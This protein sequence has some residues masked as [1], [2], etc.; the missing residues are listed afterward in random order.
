METFPEKVSFV[1]AVLPEQNS[2]VK[3]WVRRLKEWIKYSL[4]AAVWASVGFAMVLMPFYSK[5]ESHAGPIFAKVVLLF[6][7]LALGVIIG[8]VAWG[9]KCLFSIKMT[10]SI[11]DI[12]ISYLL[13]LFLAVIS[14]SIVGNLLTLILFGMYVAGKTI[15]RKVFIKTNLKH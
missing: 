12:P 15:Y 2:P 8:T 14:L 3:F 7:L 1:D 11:K 4:W 5:V 6:V 13:G 10:N 9:A